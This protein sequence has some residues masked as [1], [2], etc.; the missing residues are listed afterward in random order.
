MG[1]RRGI[2]MGLFSNDR[3]Q[4]QTKKVR[5]GNT[6]KVRGVQVHKDKKKEPEKFDPRKAGDW[7]D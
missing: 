6:A 7:G 4:R 3:I 5:K 2:L 1:R